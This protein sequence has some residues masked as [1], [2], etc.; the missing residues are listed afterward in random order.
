MIR[1]DHFGI[2]K[3]SQR[4]AWVGA[5]KSVGFLFVFL[6]NIYLART[7]SQKHFG[8]YQQ[9]WLFIHTSLPILLL[10]IPQALNYLLPPASQEKTRQYI[11]AF[12]LLLFFTGLVTSLLALSVPGFLAGLIGN[13]E[14]SI[15]IPVIG[16]YIFVFLPFNLLE[17]LLILKT[18]VRELFLW[19]VLLNLLFILIILWGGKIKSLEKIFTALAVLALV[20]MIIASQRTL[21]LYGPGS[22]RIPRT[23]W[24]P[25]LRYLSILAGISLV[26]IF[27]MDIDKYVVSHFL[28]SEKYALYSVGAIEIPVITLLIGSVTAVVMPE[29]TR[30]LSLDK[31]DE[32]IRLLHR[33][34]E[35]LAF[36]ILPLFIYCALTAG[37]YIP[38]FFGER[39][40]ASIAIFCIYL[41]LMPIRILNNHPYLISAGLQRYA[42]Y[43]RILDIFINF[44]LGIILIRWIG[45][46]GPAVST[47]LASYIHKVYQTAIM[48]KHLGLKMDKIYPWKQ[49]LRIL[50]STAPGAICLGMILVIFGRSLASI[51]IGSVL[52]AGI[53]L[54]LLPPLLKQSHT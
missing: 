1:L 53:Y 19:S 30:F 40:Q 32:V 13:P 52:F 26:D 6:A 22:W 37:F 45:L 33:S 8:L 2:G 43:A 23:L 20:K 42:L 14:L 31:K 29:M 18:R 4:T 49:F 50:V 17:P 39:Y 11:H 25:L 34:M 41:V 9:G 3:L 21:A 7:L 24:S 46:W 12:F 35:K 10:G 54:I 51:I 28:G 16:L 36:V 47:V 15:L 5:S 48:S 27:T 44:I 38:F